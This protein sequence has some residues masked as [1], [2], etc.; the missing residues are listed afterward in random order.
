MIYAAIGGITK[1]FGW[2]RPVYRTEPFFLVYSKYRFP[3]PGICAAERVR[4]KIMYDKVSTDLNF[5]DRG[6]K[7]EKF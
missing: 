6:K 3:Q 2:L 1:R 4:R 7:V 5:M